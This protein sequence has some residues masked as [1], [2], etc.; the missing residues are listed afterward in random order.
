MRFFLAFR[1]KMAPISKKHQKQGLEH[2]L[3]EDAGNI[4][5]QCLDII[6]NILCS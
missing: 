6:Y 2:P 1:P 4:H 3:L 5:A